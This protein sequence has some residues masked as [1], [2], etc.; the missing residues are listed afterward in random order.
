MGYGGG[1]KPRIVRGQ[2]TAGLPNLEDF[3]QSGFFCSEKRRK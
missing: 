1:A 3:W 2:T